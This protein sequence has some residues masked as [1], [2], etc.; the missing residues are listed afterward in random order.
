[1]SRRRSQTASCMIPGFDGRE[2]Y[3]SPDSCTTSC[4]T[5]WNLCCSLTGLVR[6]KCPTT[7]PWS[8]IPLA[9]CIGDQSAVLPAAAVGD[10]IEVEH[11]DVFPQKR[12]WSEATVVRPADNLCGLVDVACRAVEPSERAQS[13][14]ATSAICHPRWSQ[15]VFRGGVASGRN[16][17]GRAMCFTGE[18]AQG[19]PA[20]CATGCC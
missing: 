11:P 2:H 18:N 14:G 3:I 4:R 9:I 19:N 10:L 7:W 13:G 1:M 6:V 8:L 12:D 5:L 16:S 15:R 20:E 17:R